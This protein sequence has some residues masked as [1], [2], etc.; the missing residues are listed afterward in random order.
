MP[1]QRPWQLAGQVPEG[2]LTGRRDD[3]G[4]TARRAELLVP[5]RVRPAAEL[6]RAP[7]SAH[8][9]ARLPRPQG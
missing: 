2:A 4:G 3:G 5:V 8:G 1:P 7:S 9:A 6:L